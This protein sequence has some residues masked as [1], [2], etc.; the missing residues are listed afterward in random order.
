MPTR[1]PVRPARALT[2]ALIVLAFMVLL[3]VAAALLA[4]APAV[5]VI[6]P[7]APTPTTT[8][9]APAPAARPQRVVALSPAIALT[10]RTLGRADAL[11]GRHAFDAW[12][13]PALPI[14]GDQAGLDYEALIRVD[15]T[16]VL[17]QTSALRD[18]P[19]R[20]TDLA[21]QRRWHVR[22]LPMLTLDQVADALALLEADFAPPT[23]PAPPAPGAP[24][25]T[26]PRD[27]ATKTA[28][29]PADSLAQRLRRAAAPRQGLDAARAGRV[30][31]L[32]G[33][34]PPAALGPGSFH[35]DLLV[36]LGATPALTRGQPFMA[37]STEDLLA[38]KP[39]A[40]ILVAPRAPEPPAAPDPA[41]PASITP[42]AAGPRWRFVPAEQWPQWLGRAADLAL[43]ALR[44]RDPNHPR[45][46]LAGPQAVT[47]V[48]LFDDPLAAVPG[49]NLID[50][51]DDLAQVLA[52]WSAPAPAQPAPRAEPSAAR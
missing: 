17:L 2:I 9:P 43:P 24:H 26:R 50:L 5:N 7:P 11:A 40:I 25:S 37:L 31:I 20:L 30:L 41:D 49:P 3:S 45:D 52:A 46:G 13:D 1:P 38:L 33:G 6:P 47:R 44:D 42:A 48:A 22:A 4:P 12:S 29:G 23:P 14:C 8:T 28:S 19:P 36:R 27:A 10:L 35:H 16:H 34:S 51:A 15:P 32:Y 39:D 21:A 18:I